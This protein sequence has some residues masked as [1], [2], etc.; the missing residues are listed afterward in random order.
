MR[1]ALFAYCFMIP[2]IWKAQVDTSKTI[3]VKKTNIFGVPFR[4][5]PS[6]VIT[7]I[8]KVAISGDMLFVIG[9]GGNVLNYEVLNYELSYMDIK[10]NAYITFACSGN[11]LDVRLQV[12][13]NEFVTINKGKYTLKV[14][15]SCV[16]MDKVYAKDNYTGSI[17]RIGGISLMRN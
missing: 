2:A 14:F 6:G 13:L 11:S 12:V 5:T 10:T 15:T 7:G 17:K 9:K 1:S 16:Y 8:H 4:C 3:D